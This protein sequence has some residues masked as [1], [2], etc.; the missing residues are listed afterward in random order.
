MSIEE[1]ITP[2]NVSILILILLLIFLIYKKY[3]KNNTYEHMLSTSNISLRSV[4]IIPELK[5]IQNKCD[6]EGHLGSGTN[7]M[8]ID[9]LITMENSAD[10]N[11][12]VLK[13]KP[14]LFNGNALYRMQRNIRYSFGGTVNCKFTIGSNSNGV[15]FRLLKEYIVSNA[16][17]EKYIDITNQINSLIKKLEAEGIILRTSTTADSLIF[18]K[19]ILNTNN[20]YAFTFVQNDNIY[21]N[22]SPTCPT[23]PKDDNVKTIYSPEETTT[24]FNTQQIDINKL[25]QKLEILKYNISGDKNAYYNTQACGCLLTVPFSNTINKDINIW[26]FSIKDISLKVAK[27][28]LKTYLYLECTYN[29]DAKN[30]NFIG[31]VSFTQ[32]KDI[33]NVTSIYANKK[34]YFS[35][36]LIQKIRDNISK[37]NSVGEL[38]QIY[39]DF[40]EEFIVKLL[41]SYKNFNYYLSVRRLISFNID[42][43]SN[44]LGQKFVIDNTLETDTLSFYVS[45]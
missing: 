18:D 23:C 9:V 11:S 39:P 8:R 4:S 22:V 26:H 43:I 41:D 35:D 6:S 37:P 34:F 29:E 16:R 36:S 13:V 10:L 14:I 20:Y 28:G 45:Q 2:F 25:N 42:E 12:I 30:T 44:I 31:T 32:E 33:N 1:H 5:A 3:Q 21:F 27:K 15:S 24:F 19:K 17:Q 40:S 7:M 38:K